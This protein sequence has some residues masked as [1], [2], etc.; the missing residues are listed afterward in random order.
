MPAVIVS[1][2]KSNN[3]LIG[4]I[5]VYFAKRSRDWNRGL[6][7]QETMGA[8]N[9]HWVNGDALAI[10][11]GWEGTSSGNNISSNISILSTTLLTYLL[12]TR[13][14]TNLASQRRV[15]TD[16]LVEQHCDEIVATKQRYLF[17]PAPNHN[18]LF[19]CPAQLHIRSRKKPFRDLPCSSI[20]LVHAIPGFQVAVT[21]N[22]VSPFHASLLA[23]YDI[24][25]RDKTQVQVPTE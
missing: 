15:T 11:R 13:V 18:V 19:L 22:T 10:R 9:R 4:A 20:A 5:V 7:C 1:M 6:G 3:E 14:M 21:E 8:D 24:I 17:V 25:C 2:Q 23:H 12:R 16:R